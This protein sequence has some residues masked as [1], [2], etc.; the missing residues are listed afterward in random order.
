MSTSLNLLGCWRL[1]FPIILNV[2]IHKQDEENN[3]V[4]EEKAWHECWEIAASAKSAD[5]VEDAEHKLSL[6]KYVKY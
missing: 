6:K 2:E 3:G 5:V 1:L 4:E